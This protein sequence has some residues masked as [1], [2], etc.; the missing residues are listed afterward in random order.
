MRFNLAVEVVPDFH[1]C[2]QLLRM[3]F[4]AHLHDALLSQMALHAR[5]FYETGEQLVKNLFFF[6]FSIM[7]EWMGG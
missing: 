3:H 6:F 1:A 2:F 7:F 5:F 4:L